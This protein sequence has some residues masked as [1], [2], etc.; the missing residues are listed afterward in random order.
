MNKFRF[1]V[2]SGFAMALAV[3]CSTESSAPAIIITTT[4]DSGVKTD[5]AD[6]LASADLAPVDAKTIT[7]IL[8]FNDLAASDR[9]P[10]VVADAFADSRPDDLTPDVSDRADVATADRAVIN[11]T[12]GRYS[13]R[14]CA[15]ILDGGDPIAPLDTIGLTV[16]VDPA[17]GQVTL[18][19]F[20]ASDT[21]GIIPVTDGV[22]NFTHGRG[23]N[24]G[25]V[26]PA[27]GYSIAGS[28][29]SPTEIDGQFTSIGFCQIENSGCFI[30]TLVV[31]DA[32]SA[33]DTG[34]DGPVINPLAGHYTAR[35]DPAVLDGGADPI[36]PLDL[37]GFTV[38][39]D[40]TT[41]ALSVTYS[42]NAHNYYSF[43]VSNSAFNYEHGQGI[44]GYGGTYCP[45]DG[46][47]IS[48]SFLSPTEAH[49]TYYATSS[50]RVQN[51]GFFIATR[52]AN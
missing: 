8:I 2:Y 26:C 7:D 1:W 23:G 22:F 32:G 52:D 16:N 21:N 30:A 38:S 4:S 37:F 50:C 10:I 46:F 24:D 35:P 41:G 39:A 29:V 44:D 5:R 14:P 45:T 43:P 11:P 20:S 6:S 13:V 28:F 34:P 47:A 51:A 3:G 36:T 19:F 25:T 33:A 42:S 31:P 12:S 40:A 27:N 49:G 15:P 48:G 17:S 18:F 9:P